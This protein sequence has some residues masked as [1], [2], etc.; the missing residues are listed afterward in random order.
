MQKPRVRLSAHGHT[1][2]S[3][4]SLSSSATANLKLRDMVRF[5]S[6]RLCKTYSNA[7]LKVGIKCYILVKKYYKIICKDF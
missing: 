6:E 5:L 2:V 7:G 3:A 1:S 4:F